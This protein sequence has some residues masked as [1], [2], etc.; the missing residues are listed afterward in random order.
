MKTPFQ[1]GALEQAFSINQ[2]PSDDV[3]RELGDRLGLTATQVMV[4]FKDRRRRARAEEAAAR[5]EARMAKEKA[6]RLAAERGEEVVEEEEPARPILMKPAVKPTV[7]PAVKPAVKLAPPASMGKGTGKPKAAESDGETESEATEDEDLA[8]A[9]A[10]E[11]EEIIALATTLLP[12]E[13][14]PGGP[15]LGFEFD[16]PPGKVAKGS[17]RKRVVTKDGEGIVMDDGTFVTS[18]KSKDDNG[19]PGSSR[20]LAQAEERLKK[21]RMEEEM[22]KDKIRKEAE[23]RAKKE[24][25]RALLLQQRLEMAMKKEAERVER[26]RRKEEERLEREALKE[27]MKLKKE[28]ERLLLAKERERQKEEVARERERQREEAAKERERIK[29]EQARERKRQQEEAARERERIAEERRAEKVKMAEERRKEME[30]RRAEQ[31]A[32]KERRAEERRRE[33]EIQNAMR[34]QERAALKAK[35]REMGIGSVEDEELEWELLMKKRHEEGYGSDTGGAAGD[36]EPLERPPFPPPS[37]TLREAF[38]ASLK[39]TGPDVLMVWAFCSSFPELLGLWPSCVEDLLAAVVEGSGSRLLAEMHISLIKLALADMEESHAKGVLHQGHTFVDRAVYNAAHHLEEAWA[40]GF[41]TDVWRAH[42]NAIT[43]PEVLRQLAVALGHGRRRPRLTSSA[44]RV[45]GTEGEDTVELGEGGLKLKMPGRMVPGTLKAGAWTVLCGAGAEG[46]PVGEIAERVQAEGLRDL[47]RSRNPEAAVAKAVM[48][49]AVFS[50]VR[51]GV[52]AL[53]AVVMAV[54][55]LEDPGSLAVEVLPREEGAGAGAEASEV[56]TMEMEEAEDDAIDSSHWVFKLE[57]SD[58]NQLTL[59]ERV[60]VLVMLVDLANNGPTLRA[61]LEAR[62]AEGSRVRKQ[63]QDDNKA[64]RQRKQAEAAAKAAEVA[65]EAM[66]ALEKSKVDEPRP[67]EGEDDS[68]QPGN[69]Y[70]E[71]ARKAMEEAEGRIKAAEGVQDVEALAAEEERKRKERQEAIRRAEEATAI[72]LKPFGAD[73]RCNRYWRLV[74]PDSNTMGDPNQGR[75]FFEDHVSGE[76]ALLGDEDA[77]QA[78]TGALMERGFREGALLKAIK[79]SEKMMLQHMPSKGL[80]FPEPPEDEAV[81]QQQSA[82]CLSQSTCAS[83]VQQSHAAPRDLT[84]T[85][86]LTGDTPSEDMPLMKLK[87]DMLEMEMALPRE[88]VMGL[89]RET[90]RDGVGMAVSADVLRSYLGELESAVSP[91][92]ISADYR[93]K[94]HLVKGAWITCGKEVLKIPG[95][96]EEPQYVADYIDELSEP[97]QWLPPTVASVAL[98]LQALDSALVYARG[99]VPARDSLAAYRYIQR[100]TPPTTQGI[101]ALFHLRGHRFGDR[102]YVRTVFCGEA[103]QPPRLLPAF[104]HALLAEDPAA[105]ELPLEQLLAP[106][107][108]SDMHVERMAPGRARGRAVRGRGPTAKL[109]RE[110]PWA[111]DVSEEG[112]G[113]TERRSSRPHAAMGGRARGGGR[114]S[115]SRGSADTSPDGSREPAGASSMDVGDDGDTPDHSD[116]EEEEES[117]PDAG[118]YDSPDD[119]SESPEI[120]DMEDSD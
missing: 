29:E 41:E 87:Q 64:E 8:A 9:E 17:K 93:L 2:Y 100:P 39:E 28:E 10:R 59:Q 116:E 14:R 38:A 113:R 45:V 58:Y 23:R 3:R 68:S 97:L 72:R 95:P 92:Y 80:A 42:L 35:Q 103:K 108:V 36:T 84:G 63:V 22:R 25:E 91:N 34:A 32:E 81:A 102:E 43:W 66:K 33:R 118:A 46:L 67:G 75:I 27:E 96:N 86:M 120:S 74:R 7:K 12:V 88:A 13:I 61:R 85:T 119:E 6:A 24:A 57:K 18:K 99:L 4:W 105:F 15:R 16:P 79:R 112:D 37:M 117:E 55:Q 20:A 54:S 65:R 78:L 70:A 56:T 62:M 30:K 51:P 89:D 47:S 21:R 48:R 115:V 82:W 109:S 52:Y 94:P 76:M 106:S 1:K 104:P 90:W 40:W 69:A 83:V 73:R 50:R 49:D 19:G 60:Q 110:A 71:A 31:Q 44:A 107:V 101:G 114:S 98:R 26:E 11:R 111:E 53:H 77:L 5:V